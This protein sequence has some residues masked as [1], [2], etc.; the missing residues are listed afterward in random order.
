M[1]VGVTQ[2]VEHVTAY[3]EIRDCLD[4]RWA[5]F[6]NT[7]EMTMIPIPNT[8][9]NVEGWL[10][11][12]KCDAYLLTGGNDLADLPNAKNVSIERDRTE[13]ALLKYAQSRSTPVFGV[14]RGLQLIN[15]FLGGQLDRVLGHVANR[16]SVRTCFDQG[17]KFIPS[18]V[19]SFHDWGIS[20]DSLSTQLI[21]C[22][23][24]TDNY[25]ESARHGKLNWLG[26]MWHPEREKEFKASDLE[27]LRKLF[28][29]GFS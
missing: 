10:D 17:T 20:I 7:L 14:C 23:Y 4:Q 19:N 26:I 29:E 5:E 11:V 24:D 3:A 28:N 25:V 9:R 16:H 12:M 13:I 18:N 2:R 22:A 1:R 21:P 6:L 27:I 15:V 8:L